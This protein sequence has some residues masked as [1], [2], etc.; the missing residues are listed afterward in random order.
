MVKL[1]PWRRR[2]W[3]G[4]ALGGPL[5]RGCRFCFAAHDGEVTT[6]TLAEW[7]G[8]RSSTRAASRRGGR[9]T[10][11]LARCGAKPLFADAASNGS[12]I[13]AGLIAL[14]Y[15]GNHARFYFYIYSATTNGVYFFGSCLLNGNAEFPFGPQ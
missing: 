10:T 9:C 1:P 7:I 12:I 14:S 3:C 6:S 8:R 11:T 13:V 4:P 15:N 2:R 5:Q